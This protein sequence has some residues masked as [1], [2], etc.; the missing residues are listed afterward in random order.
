MH[1]VIEQARRLPDAKLGPDDVRLLTKLVDRYPDAFVT[2]TGL[3]SPGTAEDF[4]VCVSDKKATTINEL[5]LECDEAEASFGSLRMRNSNVN[6]VCL[7]EDYFVKW[8]AATAMVSALA[9]IAERSVR[10]GVFEALCGIAA[11]TGVRAKQ[12]ETG[13]AVA[14][15]VGGPIREYDDN[16]DDIPNPRRVKSAESAVQAACRARGDGDDDVTEDS[17]LDLLA[18]LGHLCDYAGVDF[19]KSIL[20]ALRRWNEEQ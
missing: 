5:G 3:W 12:L 18:D 11:A 9:P 16:G 2:G 20:W 10:H 19:E 15:N 8:Q 4:D 7:S 6:I 17:I 1:L 14:A 13:L